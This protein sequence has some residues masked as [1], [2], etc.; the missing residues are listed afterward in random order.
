M[1]RTTKAKPWPQISDGKIE[2]TRKCWL[3]LRK[4][5]RNQFSIKSPIGLHSTL[6]WQ[7]LSKSRL[8]PQPETRVSGDPEKGAAPGAS[9]LETRKC[10][11]DE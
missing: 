10:T 11:I 4:P 2:S 5:I 3:A 9:L 6:I 8:R 7:I 1:S